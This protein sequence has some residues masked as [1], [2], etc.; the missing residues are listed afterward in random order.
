MMTPLKL[1]L[2]GCG[3]IVQNSH[4]P[5]LLEQAAV[6]EIVAVADPMKANRDLVGDAAEVDPSQRYA[7]YRDMLARAALDIVTIATPHHLHHEQVL[8]AAEAGVAIISEKPM[9][10]SLEEADAILEAVKHVPYAV[11][12][13]FLFAPGTRAALDLLATGELGA[14]IFG[15][16][17][18]L[19]NKAG[20]QT[21]ELW[22]NQKAA[23]GGAINDTAYH[24]I[25][26]VEAM[27][28]S[29]VRYVEARVQTKF[30][31]FDVD[32]LALLMLEHENGVISTVST[33]W[34]IPAPETTFCEAHT[35]VG[36]LQ[37][38]GRG[39]GLRRYL[40]TERQ[41]EDVHLP[42]ID[43]LPTGAIGRAGHANYFAATLK[44]LAAGTEVPV[45]GEKARH[46]LAIIHAARQATIER[47]A[48]A[49]D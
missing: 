23:G 21:A 27:V 39:S 36:S 13:N 16:A 11:V 9:A 34:C 5:G 24:E 26:L 29:P 28:G 33:A 40:R 31:S 32:D 41:W 44:A 12:H 15:R 37:V 19:F 38:I 20:D 46:N 8:A 17:Q 3:G 25:Y 6:A 22:R 30:F 10:T 47:R 2:M 35:P 14:P 45:T 42:E 48:V 7:D 18:S 49:V 4:L 1:G 43:A